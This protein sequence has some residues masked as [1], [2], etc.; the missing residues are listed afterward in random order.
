MTPDIIVEL[1]KV[2][3]LLPIVVGI[4]YFSL[5]QH[6]ALRLVEENRA[7]DQKAIVNRLIELSDKWNATINQ[8]LLVNQAATDALKELRQSLNE[9]RSAIDRGMQK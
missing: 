5:I 6:K 4:A 8:L 3:I 9:L 7:D 2:S 1:V